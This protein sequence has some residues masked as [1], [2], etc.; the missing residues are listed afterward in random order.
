LIRFS[1][2]CFDGNSGD[3]EFFEDGFWGHIF[4]GWVR[5]YAL[6]LAVLGNKSLILLSPARKKQRGLGEVS[7]PP[8][9]TVENAPAKAL[10]PQKNQRYSAD[11][12][13]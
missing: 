11:P 6:A 8:A 9:P 3:D 7:P 10:P 5:D 13:Q 12:S 4:C 1:V 2:G